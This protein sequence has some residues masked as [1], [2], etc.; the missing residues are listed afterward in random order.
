MAGRRQESPRPRSFR[1]TVLAGAD[2][3]RSARVRNPYR[4]AENSSRCGLSFLTPLP[5]LLSP[6]ESQEPKGPK[7]R[8]QFAEIHS[9]ASPVRV[10][11]S[12]RFIDLAVT[13]FSASHC[14][15]T[16]WNIRKH[17]NIPTVTHSD[18]QV[19]AKYIALIQKPTCPCG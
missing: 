3:W 1:C 19:E 8:F 18:F 2:F 6:A 17:T 5:G 15:S 11:V 9:F 13:R 7:S 14:S 10:S 16:F 4:M 12:E